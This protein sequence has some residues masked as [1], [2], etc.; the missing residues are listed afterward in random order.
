MGLRVI[1][2]ESDRPQVGRNRVIKF[3]PRPQRSSKSRMS[4]G[5][6]GPDLNR[7]AV[8][9]RCMTK[10]FL[11][12]KCDSKIV[13]GFGKV[14]LEPDSPLACGHCLIETAFLVEQGAKARIGLC[15]GRYDAD[16]LAIGRSGLGALALLTQRMAEVEIGRGRT[17]INRQ[18]TSKRGACLFE[19]PLIAQQDTVIDMNLGMGRSGAQCRK[20]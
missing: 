8:N 17:G 6:V 1:R 14:R 16:D 3:A 15:G 4:F 7:L 18:R 12:S 11:R 2:L 9:R 13:I 19:L 10:F 5:I 20:A